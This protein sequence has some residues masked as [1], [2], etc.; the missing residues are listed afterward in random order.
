MPRPVAQTGFTAIDIG[1]QL[2]A[3]IAEPDQSR[4]RKIDYV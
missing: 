2:G 4:S 3:L 1:Y